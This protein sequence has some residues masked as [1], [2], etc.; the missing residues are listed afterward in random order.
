MGIILSLGVAKLLTGIG[1][2]IEHPKRFGW[3]WV[4]MN[5]VL[6]AF[7]SIVTFWWWE[8]GLGWVSGWTLASYMFVIVYC[9][10][11]F[12]IATLLFPRDVDG[13]GSYENYLIQ[14]RAWFF[15][16]IAII[17]LMDLVDT[18]IKGKGHWAMLGAAYPI[19]VAALLLIAGLGIWRSS[20]NAQL[21]L[22][23]FA[24]IY[25]VIYVVV[26]YFTPAWQ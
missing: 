22:S 15:G 21:L 17:T 13:F 12:M 5:W 6:W 3:S 1:S 18:S 24:V 8:F 4:H 25:Q 26:E 19:H 7:V 20:K 16:L 10:L 14:R 11:Y 23:L 9:A 2:I